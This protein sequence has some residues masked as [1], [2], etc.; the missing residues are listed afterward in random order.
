MVHLSVTR[1][2]FASLT[3]SPRM[4]TPNGDGV[5]DQATATLSLLNVLVPRPLHLK[6]F[7]LSGRLVKAVEQEGKAGQ[8]HLLW[9]GRNHRDQLVPPGVYIIEVGVE[10]DAGSKT[11]RQLVSVAY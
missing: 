8:Q 2:L 11:T 1:D 4:I 6:V 7:D 5:N 9:D 10:G 3:L